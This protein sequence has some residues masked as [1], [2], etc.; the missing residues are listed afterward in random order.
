MNKSVVLIKGLVKRYGSFTAVGGID[1]D[2]LRGE[3]FGLL[4][5]NGAGKT[6]TLECL[7]GMRK[8]DGGTL[9]VAGCDPQSQEGKLR[10]K[11]GVQLQSSSL[12]DSIRVEEAIDLI[13]A[14]HGLPEQ[15]D[16]IQKFGI[17]D[18]LKKQYR[19]LSTGQKRRLHLV[20]AL[21]NNPEV[22]VLD[23]PTAGL[24]VQ[25]RAQLHD[26]IRSIKSQGI[27]VLLATHDMAE[28]EALCDRIAIMI[29]G[30]IAICGTP[31]QVTASGSKETRIRMR[32]AKGSLLPGGDID[33]ATFVKAK[34]GYLEWNCSN[35]APSV[36]EIL[37][38]V[39]NLGDTVED[40]R[41]ERPSLEERFL[42]LVEGVENK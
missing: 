38:R 41:V 11:L 32:T 13:A 22:I 4:G 42:E 8:A 1:I 14:W 24:D 6:T 18:L 3:V 36:T 26:E 7:E 5:P 27:T 37:K 35:V 2:V 9:R 30:K 12:P 19:E 15:S 28:A 16:L 40:L 10:S 21:V 23:E 33:G 31:E 17:S 29:R 20:L 25:S 39:Q 34:E